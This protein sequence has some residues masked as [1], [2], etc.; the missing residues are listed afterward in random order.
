MVQL[1]PSLGKLALHLLLLLNPLAHG[2][3]HDSPLVQLLAILTQT[4]SRTSSGA[5]RALCPSQAAL[6]R[7]LRLQKGPGLF[8]VALFELFLNPL[9]RAEIGVTI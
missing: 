7:P 2:L 5:R 1:L 6:L 4:S 9:L 3:R 8:V